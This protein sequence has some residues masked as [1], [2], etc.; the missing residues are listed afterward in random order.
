MR[1]LRVGR[2]H[3]MEHAVDGADARGRLAASVHGTHLGG[4]RAGRGGGRRGPRRRARGVGRRRCRRRGRRGLLV[5]ALPGNR[6]SRPGPCRG[7]GSCPRRR[8]AR[9]SA[10]G[11]RRRVA[12][13]ASRTGAATGVLDAGGRARAAAPT[14]CARRCGAAR[15]CWRAAARRRGAR[16]PAPV[17]A[18]A[19]GVDRAES[20]G[21]RRAGRRGRP[22]DGRRRWTDRRAR[23]R[24]TVLPPPSS[25]NRAGPSG[26]TAMTT[27]RA[28]SRR[29]GDAGRRAKPLGTSVLPE[30]CAGGVD[31]LST[32][33]TRR[34]VPQACGY[35][36]SDRSRPPA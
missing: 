12:R 20:R 11:R 6:R 25:H 1:A 14:A 29:G 36:G 16:S 28:S 34:D 9:G 26:P 32:A 8:R 15:G 17:P 31:I 3:A 2:W 23:F 24:S 35:P 18:S 21:R 33:S 4:G 22:G 7:R 30:R 13:S 27:A 5:D 10:T 19:D